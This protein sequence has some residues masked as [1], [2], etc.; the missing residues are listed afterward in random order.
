MKSAQERPSSPLPLWSGEAGEMP[1]DVKQ[2]INELLFY[3]LPSSVT[4]GDME[5]LAAE[6]FT[7]INGRW[8][9]SSQLARA[10]EVR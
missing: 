7:K 6:I 1:S 8:F 10:S 3:S 9:Q 5:I 2:R 4:L